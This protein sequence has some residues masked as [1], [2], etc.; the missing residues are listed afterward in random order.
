[1]SPYI[2]APEQIDTLADVAWQ[3][4]ELATKD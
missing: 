4:I 2:I 1:M 3:E